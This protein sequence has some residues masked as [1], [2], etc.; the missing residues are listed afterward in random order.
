MTVL[1][2]RRVQ[3]LETAIVEHVAANP[4]SNV[5]HFDG[6]GLS[7]PGVKRAGPTRV[8]SAARTPLSAG[9]WSAP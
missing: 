5:T 8:G 1:L 3:L 2:A 4:G 9:G 7:C 6:L